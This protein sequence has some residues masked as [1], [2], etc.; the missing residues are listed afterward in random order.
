MDSFKNIF[1]R[2]I[3]IQSS[4]TLHMSMSIAFQFLQ[5]FVCVDIFFSKAYILLHKKG[6]KLNYH[7]LWILFSLLS[8]DAAARMVSSERKYLDVGLNLL[9]K[10]V[11]PF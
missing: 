5:L 1:L 10:C 7:I 6:L 8:L 11:S 2:I 3:W 4:L 9:K